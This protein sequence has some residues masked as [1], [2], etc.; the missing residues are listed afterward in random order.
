MDIHRRLEQV[1]REAFNNESLVLRDE[2]SSRDIAGWDSVAHVNLMFGIESAFGIQFV[3]NELAELENIGALKEC[4]FA[5]G[6][7]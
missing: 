5:K 4:L 2:F 1:F 7:K 3:G 6:A